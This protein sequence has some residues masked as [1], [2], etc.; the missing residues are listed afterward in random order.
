[1]F[2]QLTK[3]MEGHADEKRKQ[4]QV[5]M[6]YVHQEWNQLRGYVMIF[7]KGFELFLHHDRRLVHHVPGSQVLNLL[8]SSLRLGSKEK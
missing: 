2:R 3:Q 7:Q 1:M 5:G 4:V 8:E 6:A